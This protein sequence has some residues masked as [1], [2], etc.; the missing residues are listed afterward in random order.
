VVDVPAVDSN[1]LKR[2][3]AEAARHLDTGDERK[4]LDEAC[5]LAVAVVAGCRSAAISEARRR[6][7]GT[8]LAASDGVA[9]ELRAV[10]DELG[11]GPCA[12]S[13][14]D[15]RVVWCE[16]F[17]TEERWPLFAAE[18][19]SRGIRGAVA[20]QLYT[21]GGVLGVLSL[22][23]A[24]PGAFDEV[25]R[26]VAQIFAAHAA[27]VLTGARKTTQL[28]H[29]LI[30]RQRIG[31][32]TGLLAERHGLTTGEAFSML[33]RISQDHNTRLR[34]LADAFITAEDEGRHRE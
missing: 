33:V 23:S 13:I 19:L 1:D 6:K 30:T 11:E 28:S 20:I 3:L 16:D 34:D 32:A 21:H 25:T 14:W 2:W 24:H 9:R 17:E 10:Q 7:P 5:R 15:E 18:A 31:E 29:G 27:V 12:V 22:Y 8:V 4:T 26:D